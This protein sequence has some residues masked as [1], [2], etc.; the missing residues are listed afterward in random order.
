MSGGSIDTPILSGKAY[1]EGVPSP[2]EVLGYD[3]GERITSYADMRRYLDALV[4]SSDRVRL[5]TYGTTYEG[6]D[7]LCLS[8]SSPHNLGA[9][10]SIKARLR[11]LADP[12]LLSSP[13]EADAICR[14]TPIVTWL[15]HN[16]HGNEL[17][18]MEAAL[19]TAYHL[20]A[21]E[22]DD[23]HAILDG[24]V[25]I[26]DPVQN[27]D[28]RERA[29]F[30]YRTAAGPAP[31]PDKHA[32]EHHEPWP[33]GRGNHYL[34]DLNRDLFALTQVETRARIAAVREWHPQ[35]FADLHEMGPNATYY[36]LPP[37]PPVNANHPAIIRHWWEV[38]GRAI[39]S[40]FDAAGFDYYARESFDAFFPGY[41]ESWPSHQGATGITLEQ[42]SAEGIC[43]KRDDGGLLTLADAA[44]HHFVA[45]MAICSAAVEH[46]EERL[47]AFLH[48]HQEAIESGASGQVRAYLLPASNRAADVAELVERLR[49]QGIEAHM[50]RNPFQVEVRPLADAGELRQMEM[51]AG[52]YVLPLDQPQGRLLQALFERE[53]E[54]DPEFVA[55]E[56]ERDRANVQSQVYDITAWSVPLAMGLPCFEA[57]SGVDA[58]V[59]ETA[60]SPR[61]TGRTPMP[62]RY[63]CV[64]SY[65]SNSAAKLLGRLLCENVRVHVARSPLWVGGQE[66]QRG[67]LVVKRAANAERLWEILDRLG[68]ETGVELT[69]VDSAWTEK[70]ACLGGESVVLVKEPR[71]AILYGEPCIPT[72]CGACLYLM[73]QVYHVPYTAVRVPFLR[74]GDLREYNVILL[75]DGDEAEY[76][77]MLGEDA[78]RLKEWVSFGGTLVAVGGAAAFAARKEHELTSSRIVTDLRRRHEDEDERPKEQ[79]APGAPAPP[80]PE[81]P[82]EHRPKAIPGAILRVDLDSHSFLT[83]GYDGTVNVIATSSRILTPSK[84]GRNVARYAPEDRLRVAGLLWDRMAKALPGSSYM[85]HE[86]KGSGHVVLLAEDPFFRASWDGLHR[87]LLN[88]IFFGPSME[89]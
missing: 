63:G 25:V 43:I 74:H 22:D 65:A 56:L 81:V 58:D 80:R 70:G 71:L 23:V 57:S 62:S 50:A 15:A 40:S 33:G 78:K 17:S 60:A 36:F 19:L 2:R 82:P 48:Y 67:S 16:V 32:A 42:A 86:R 47:R 38:F 4:G 9:L 59:T 14:E 24:S 77:R 41:G 83:M 49:R 45:A 53:P 35:V 20:A 54:I 87:L 21:C 6:R 28:G 64:V 76:Q 12:R 1:R 29:V 30:Y 46:R 75:P 66:L 34:F 73:D 8:I 26:I 31:N 68:R 5:A 18:T 69:P 88:A 7:L 10:D 51:P 44:R 89:V 39:A 11:K 3:I 79:P 37:A 55:E 27:P 72:A 52:T 61:A 85:V 13:E 84:T